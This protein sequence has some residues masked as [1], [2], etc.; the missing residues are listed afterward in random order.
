MATNLVVNVRNALKDLPEPTV[1]D[2]LDSTVAFHR[3]FGN[4]QCRQ[5]VANR[6]Q[7]IRQHPQIQWRHV[8][9]ADNPEDL[10]A[11]REGKVTNTELWW[12]GPT[13]LREPES[14]PENPITVKTH[15]SEEEAKLTKEVLGL[16]SE[17]PKEEQDLIDELLERHDLRQTLCIQAWV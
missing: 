1:Y 11:T 16:A 14:W 3:I 15:A 9:T 10:A 2:W 7:K 5:F 4:G 8:P 12:N 13:W 6:V 17:Q